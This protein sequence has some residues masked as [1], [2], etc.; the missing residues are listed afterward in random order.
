M[1]VLQTTT[2]ASHGHPEFRLSYD[3]KLVPVPGDA[4]WL[5]NWLEESVARGERF[6]PGQT[7]Q[8]GWLVAQVRAGADGALELWEPDVHRLPAQWVEGVS[9]VVAHLR[10]Q[11]DVAES[12]PG[13]EFAFPSMH[14]SAIV[15]TRFA[16]ADTLILE[17]AQ[18]RGPD[19]G[20][21]CGCAEAD[22]DH[23]SLNELCRVSLYEAAVMSKLLIVPYLALPA[24]TLLEAG[25]GAPT[26][27]VNG[28]P[29]AFK[30]DS[31]LDHLSR[32]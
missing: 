8:I 26:I 17:R 30:P 4:L 7:C 11:K 1:Q 6:Q 23:D 32:S 18:P 14:Q 9:R 5:A 19:S 21:F 3:P 20:W 10:L 22:H 29:V 12:V 16:R 28:E 13:T 31:Y 15:C 27:F 2:C 24:G 25:T